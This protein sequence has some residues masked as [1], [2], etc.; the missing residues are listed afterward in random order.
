[1]RRRWRRGNGG[2]LNNEIELAP[3]SRGAF[4]TS[5][6]VIRLISCCLFL[7]FHASS[8]VSSSILFKASTSFSLQL[9]SPSLHKEGAE[10]KG[11]YWF[12]Y[13][14]RACQRTHVA[15]MREKWGS[16]RREKRSE[17]ETIWATF[18][19]I[20]LRLTSRR[21][22]CLARH[23]ERAK[24]REKKIWLMPMHALRWISNFWG[25]SN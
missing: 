12:N 19:M 16:R 13:T 2:S 4:H 17:W 24:E 6:N 1:M 18:A 20:F 10:I 9:A 15:S 14:I 7:H 22:S 3:L 11:N 21:V 23:C 5:L 25:L 8:M